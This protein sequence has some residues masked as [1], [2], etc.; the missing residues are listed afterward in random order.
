MSY[1]LEITS[2]ILAESDRIRKPF[3]APRAYDLPANPKGPDMRKI[4]QLFQDH[5]ASV[6]EGYFAHMQASFSFALPL[7]L[8]ALAAFAHGLFPFL[9]VRTGSRTIARLHERM[10]VHRR[11]AAPGEGATTPS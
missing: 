1:L 7:L 5:P 3:P 6:G 10:V 2:N 4:V 11:A 9:F 8:A